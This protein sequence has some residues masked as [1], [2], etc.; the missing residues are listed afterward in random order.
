MQESIYLSIIYYLFDC[1][2]NRINQVHRHQR[3]SYI[4]ILTLMLMWCFFGK[5]SKPKEEINSQERDSWVLE[6]FIF[7]HIFFSQD[8]DFF[9]EIFQLFTKIYASYISVFH[10]VK[11]DLFRFLQNWIHLNHRCQAIRPN[12]KGCVCPFCE[13]GL[14]LIQSVN[15]QL[16]SVNWQ[17]RVCF[18]D[19]KYVVLHA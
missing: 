11:L 4:L 19:A 9:S 3:Y 13:R 6:P 14:G 16:M 1:W 5:L 10:V 2:V 17:L 15:W 8:T 12:A 7:L 18:V